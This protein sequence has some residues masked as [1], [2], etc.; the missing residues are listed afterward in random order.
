VVADYNLFHMVNEEY[1]VVVVGTGAAGMTAALTAARHG[2]RAVVVEKAAHFGGST[3]RSGGGVWI[4]NNRVLRKDGV[5]DTPDAARTYLHAI[6]GDVVAAEKIDTYLD[7]GPEALDFVLENSP[8]RMQWVPDYSDYYPEQPGGRVGGRSIEPRPINLKKLG[9]Q[10]AHLEPDYG[11]SPLNVTVTQADFR[12]A[13]LMM[14]TPRGVLR[15]LRIG[16]RWIWSMLTRKDLAVRGQAFAAALRLGLMDAGVPVLLDTALEDLHVEDDAVTGVIVSSN[17][18]QRL[19]RAEHGVVLGSGGF[20]H[21]PAMREQYQRA[22]IGSEWTVGAKGN[23]GDG[24]LAGERL[25]A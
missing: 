10:R 4:P 1:D 16:L 8:L 5:D 25:G 12:W 24:I 22:P 7:R 15:V 20:E 19:L 2:L 17:G 23:T 9:D 14:R 6:V 3:A 21:N 13:T 11:K 18:Q